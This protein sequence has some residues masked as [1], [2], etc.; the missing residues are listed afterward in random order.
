MLRTMLL[1]CHY[2]WLTLIIFVRTIRDPLF[3]QF[4]LCKLY[5]ITSL[6]ETLNILFQLVAILDPM[7]DI[8]VEFMESLQFSLT[9]RYL[10]RTTRLREVVI[11]PDLI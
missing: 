8:F 3:I 10:D 5:E 4:F 7:I 6:D 9:S 2:I 1:S 11:L